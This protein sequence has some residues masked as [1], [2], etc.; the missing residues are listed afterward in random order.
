MKKFNL[1][2]KTIFTL[3]ISS[4]VIVFS[5][6]F[7][8]LLMGAIEDVV[9]DSLKRRL[10]TA[11]NLTEMQIAKYDLSKYKD[12][13]DKIKYADEYEKIL[14]EMRSIRNNIDG[15]KFIYT[16]KLVGT[17]VYYII[18][19][20]ESEVDR[21][22]IGE[23]YDDV[24]P[25]MFNV[26][27]NNVDK[28]F[29]EKDYNTDKYGT[30]L[31]SYNPVIKNGK[32]DYII[33]S[34]IL[35]KD[36]ENFILSYKTKFTCIFLSLVVLLVPIW[37]LIMNRIKSSLNE[38]K[39]QIIKLRDLDFDNREYVDTW[40]TD[41]IEIID[42]ADKAKV[43][44]E[45]AL[46]NVE[47]ESLLLE[48]CLISKAD[49]FGKITYANEKFCKISGYTVEELIG[50]DHKIV[51]SGVHD[52][53][54][55]RGMYDTVVK[56]KGLWSDTVTNKNK[57]GELYHVKSW[58]KGIFDKKGEFT[59]YI[60][61]RQDVTEIVKSQQEI[62]KQNT[63]LEH[64]AKI[65]RHDMHSG[66]N[67]YIPRGISSLERRLNPEVVEKYKLESPLKMLKEGLNHTQKVYRGVY[68]FTNL[69]KPNAVIELKPS[70]VKKCLEWYLS[71]TAY[72]DQVLIEDLGMLNINEALFCTAVDNLIRN[73]LKYNDSPTKY[74][75]IYKQNNYIVIEDNG[76][77]M[78]QEDFEQ[79][80]K[81]YARKEGQKESGSGLG[82]NICNA[83]LQEHGLKIKCEK[84][85]RGSESGT[86]I[87]LQ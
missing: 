56:N 79:F 54:Y 44:L 6:T 32:I 4:L 30:F 80:S 81:P 25:N 16:A 48:T 37:F 82:L 57:N 13:G 75:K 45:T 73:G 43:S 23:L 63:Y 61:V 85:S 26:F 8:F 19:C 66:I 36:A 64:A 12:E 33:G 84:W 35:I 24:A 34:D 51:N 47:S 10:N 59:G 70:D 77:G 20:E 18:D 7:Y 78:S 60:S 31:S 52:K 29:I 40:I 49:K 62:K 46:R 42:I 69:V 3:G 41:I 15:I 71:S 22:K 72:E 39:T 11:A 86:K 68:E 38:I 76:R 83:I 55:W 21:A 2:L 5:V 74:V 58:I 28:T 14:K 65:L 87:I 1:N 53:E 9:R 17:N 50:K 27:K 67:T